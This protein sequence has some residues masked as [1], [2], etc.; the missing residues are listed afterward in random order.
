MHE[1]CWQY[2]ENIRPSS[3]F[4]KDVLGELFGQAE[5]PAE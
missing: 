3:F 2:A 4:S 5:K 1:K